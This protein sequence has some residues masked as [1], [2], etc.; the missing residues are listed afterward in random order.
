MHANTSIVLSSLNFSSTG[1]LLLSLSIIIIPSV[2]NYTRIPN[3]TSW[4]IELEYIGNV[5]HFDKDLF[6]K[7]L[8]DCFSLIYGVSNIFN[9]SILK[10]RM[11]NI[12]KTNFITFKDLLQKNETNIL[13]TTKVDGEKVEFKVKN[14]ICYMI[15]NNIIYTLKTNINKDIKLVGVGEYVKVENKKVIYPFYIHS[16]NN[17]IMRNRQKS[18]LLFKELIKDNS[19][20]ISSTKDNNELKVSRD[21]YEYKQS[22]LLDIDIIHKDVYGP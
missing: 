11:P 17:K 2:T 8:I 12:L 16:I 6:R 9:I 18:L 14:G 4:Y 1:S 20:K 10:N 19:Y 21:S 3:N 5:K 7:N 15:L 22:D 13:I